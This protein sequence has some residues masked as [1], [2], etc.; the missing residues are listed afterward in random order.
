GFKLFW[1]Q[2]QFTVLNVRQ[3]H[4]AAP[5]ELQMPDHLQRKARA[6]GKL[7]SRQLSALGIALRRK[8]R[9]ALAALVQVHRQPDQA[10]FVS[11]GPGDALADPPDRVGGELVATRGVKAIQATE[12]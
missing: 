5:N 4:D 7:S 10:A 2:R 3:A 11:D 12:Q 8:T 6:V 9:K 1:P